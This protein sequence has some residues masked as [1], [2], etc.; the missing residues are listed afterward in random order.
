[1]GQGFQRS[2]MVEDE[3]NENDIWVSQLSAD[4]NMEIL[5]YKVL[6]W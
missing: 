2:I 3:L 6:V 5:F 4:V 1:M